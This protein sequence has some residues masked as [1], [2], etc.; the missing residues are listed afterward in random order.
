MTPTG[1][2]PT[3][4]TDQATAEEAEVARILDAYLADLEAGRP[5][6]PIDLLARHPVL[7]P[8][9]RACLEVMNLADQA[10]AGVA[11]G[12]TSTE[13]V[14]GQTRPAIE[15]PLST[16]DFGSSLPPHVELWDLADEPEPFL[17]P[18]SAAMPPEPLGRY[19]FQGEL[20]RGGMGAILKGRDVD[21]GRDLAIKVLL[22]SHRGNPQILQRFVE[23]A[24]IGGQ[25]Q[26]PGIVPIYELGA[27]P[28]RRPFIAMKLVKGRTLA[29]LLADR[30]VGSSPTA[31]LPRLLSIFEAVCQ[32]MAYAHA[33]GVI[34]RDLKPS[35]VM[36]GS[37]GEVQVMDWGLAKVLA[38]GGIANE[39]QAEVFSVIST[40]RSGPAGSGSD[41]QAGSVLG[42]P[43]YMA[44]E[45][46]RGEVGRLDERCDVFGLGAVLCEILTCRPPFKGA[47]REEIRRQA[48][49][50]DLAE[51]FSRIDRCGADSDL[52]ALCR[53]C[54]DADPAARP[55]NGGDV[56]DRITAHQ[57]GVQERLKATEL[58]RVEAQTRAEEAQARA[59]LERSR[60]R[61]TVALAASVLVMAAVIGGGWA[62]LVRQRAARLLATNRVVTEALAEAERLRGQAQAA[63]VGEMSKWTEAIGAA[64]R[65]RDL[66]A[67]GEAD[68]A[69]HNRVND[70]LAGLEQDRAAAQERAAEFD[71]DRT[72]LEELETIRGNL[73]EH[74]DRKRTDADYAA[75]FRGYGIDLDQ[76]DPRDAG[77]RLAQ[78][79][80]PV[81]FASHVDDWAFQR[82]KARGEN[83]EASWRRLLAAAAVADPDPWR[84]ALRVQVGLKDRST[85][86]RLAQDDKELAAQSPPSL[87]LLA[88]A[89]IDQGDRA[90]AER[91]LL[92]AW[93]IKPDE[94][95]VSYSLAETYSN[96]SSIDR[97]E[98]AARYLAAAVAIRP[99]SHAAHNGL[100]VALR[101]LGKVEEAIAEFHTALG[102]K[103]NLP[104]AHNNLGI[105]LWD[106]GKVNEAIAEFRIALRLRP[107]YSG[108]H[109][110]LG[111]ALGY[112]GKMEDAI[113]EYHTALRLRPD[114]TVAHTNLGMA[115]GDL[116]KME[117]AIAEYRTALRLEPDEPKAHYNLGNALRGQGKVEEAIAEFRT[118][119]RLK[120]DYAEAHNNLGNALVGKG[121]LEEAIAEFRTALGLQPDLP[122]AHHGLGNLLKDQGKVEEA[123]AEFRVA[124][125]L[126]PHLMEVHNNLGTALSVQGKVEEAIAEFRTAL[127]LKPDE[128]EVHYNLGNALRGQGK[129][130]EAIA[131]FRTALR[132]KPDYAAAHNNLGVALVGKGKLE[133]AIAE[134]RTALRLKPDYAEAHNNLGNAL[135]GKGKL[136]E[137][138]AEFRTSLRLKPDYAEAHN[139]LGGALVGKGKLEEAIA[140]FRT[141]LRLKPD[142]L[143]AHGNLGLALRNRGEY[144]EAIG[145]LRRALE[146][147]RINPRL[148]KQIEQVLTATERIASL[149]ARLPAIL[150][151]A[152]K[153]VDAAE[154]LSFAQLCYEKKL[155]SASARFWADALKSQLALADDRQAQHRF[156]A[157]CAAALAAAGQGKDEPKPDETAKARLRGQALVWLKAELALWT[158][159]LDSGP[160]QTRS[161]IA[162]TLQHWKADPNLAGV[163]E[164]KSLDQL[165]KAE[166]EAWLAL[167][168][169]V[170][171]VMGRAG[172]TR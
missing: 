65:A 144:T 58:R 57:A 171:R 163:R 83:D 114:L 98:E 160:P 7:A 111:M 87:V 127:R 119:L 61:R 145:E 85:L 147:A 71:R 149:A 12:S 123:I 53:D 45:Q 131:E 10:I 29:A 25:L 77:M 115:L 126:K 3:Q 107:D 100:G 44:P 60:R 151:G 93:R 128:P 153:P 113:T 50:A 141:A 95:W 48:A 103:P 2:A 97:P 39:D 105:A 82:R 122:E 162:Q 31:D 64:K 91:L 166:R 121:K 21:L 17:R 99:R 118:A 36:V 80:K 68:A 159:L 143:N 43:Q 164:G 132:L 161:A 15:S 124:L 40:V 69:L 104:E 157:A 133:E 140:E 34:H 108:A 102:L 55:R 152:A 112:Q 96:G 8:R 46:A 154:S 18:R 117:D 139:N 62:Y 170:G 137:A 165:P 129:V 74:W 66:A 51:A 73:S 156:N 1:P 125:R 89:L 19:Q 75:A 11:T 52:V 72:L 110:N 134:F 41:S 120:P 37:F 130:E 16:I 67:Q 169:E 86:R 106:Q 94:F 23:E 22:D 150:A 6:N 9:L 56:A 42:T 172:E 38:Q 81:E 32:T 14:T 54:L 168:S 47:T 33:R 13:S 49:A 30:R 28:D 35:N 88:Q 92:R 63:A 155:H 26:H 79:S 4:R 20:A 84:A 5:V 70:A 158:K 142:L 135:V 59:V 101:D 24:Q 136:E 78:R 148:A 167:W 27:F 138:I 109:S 76:L 116:G 90:L 146:L